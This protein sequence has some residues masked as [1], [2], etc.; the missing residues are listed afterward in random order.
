MGVNI[1]FVLSGFLITGILYDSQD[2][3]HRFRNFYVRR[4]LR[5]FP[6][7]YAVWTVLLLSTPWLHIAWRP[8]NFAWPAYLGN[9][10]ALLHLHGPL[11]PNFSQLV[12][13][14]F[15][16]KGD[17]VP[18][19]IFI[20]VGHFWSLCIEEQFYLFWPAVVFFVRGRSKLLKI[21]T[22]TVIVLPLLRGLFAHLVPPV[23]LETG[24]LRTFTLFHL[25]EFLL[26]G[27]AALILRGRPAPWL[28]TAAPYLF[29]TGVVA[30][31]VS[32][33]WEQY[34]QSTQPELFMR[35]EW[36]LTYGITLVDL[37]ALGM[38][39]LCLDTRS[40]LARVLNF[41]PLRGLGKV[42]Y[43]FYVF[44]DIPHALYGHLIARFG[45]GEHTTGLLVPLTG[46]LLLSVLS[47]NLLERPFLR[48][49]TRFEGRPAPHAGRTP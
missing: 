25:D 5:I 17:A 12:A 22:V 35:P 32:R 29:L 6:L 46:T 21:C 8:Q 49:K 2:R 28:R 10:L 16:A 31:L 23:A 20:L 37:M 1:F 15:F 14:P 34:V 26:G 47:Y 3:D 33:L 39:L 19:R 44:H 45:L 43:G 18:H 13:Y 40:W 24:A 7:Y 41:A 11:D 4:T 48:L 30:F 36:G 38:I 27:A 9:F 42:S